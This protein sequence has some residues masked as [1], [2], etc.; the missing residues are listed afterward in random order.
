[1]PHVIRN[2]SLLESFNAKQLRD[3][4]KKRQIKG[5]SKMRKPELVAVLL[6]A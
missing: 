4:A 5:Y 2:H 1:M 3:V 6:T